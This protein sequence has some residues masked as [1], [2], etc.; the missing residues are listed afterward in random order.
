MRQGTCTEK[1]TSSSDTFASASTAIADQAACTAP[2]RASQP[3][4]CWQQCAGQTLHMDTC[5]SS[6]ASKGMVP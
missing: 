5:I 6:E 3:W 4:S 1:C 2:R